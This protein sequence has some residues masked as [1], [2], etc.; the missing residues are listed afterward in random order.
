MLLIKREPR[1]NSNPTAI[2]Q[3]KI[4]APEQKYE[5]HVS[6]LVYVFNVVAKC[7]APPSMSRVGCLDAQLAVKT[8]DSKYPCILRSL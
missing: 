4:V 7:L 2:A 5:M 3:K 1:F 8:P 6:L